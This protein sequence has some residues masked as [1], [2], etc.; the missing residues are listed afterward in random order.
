MSRTISRTI[1]RIISRIISNVKQSIKMYADVTINSI[2]F[3]K[4]R[5]VILKSDQG[6]MNIKNH[7]WTK[8]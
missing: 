1:L 8:I 6:F 4:K 5:Y 7:L 3:Y 2:H